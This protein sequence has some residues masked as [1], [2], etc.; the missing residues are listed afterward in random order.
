[1]QEV[2]VKKLGLILILG[3]GGF[4]GLVFI[5]CAFITDF[6]LGLLVLAFYCALTGIYL[7]H[8]NEGPYFK[9]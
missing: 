3:G 9:N 6:M 5:V 7:R 4:M 2:D 8:E 1:M